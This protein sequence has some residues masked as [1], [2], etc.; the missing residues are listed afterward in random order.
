MCSRYTLI[1]SSE[2]IR[3]QFKVPAFDERLVPPR[4]NIRTDAAHHRGAPGVERA[5]PRGGANAVGADLG[6]GEGS[7]GSDLYG[8]E[9]P[10]LMACLLSVVATGRK[11]SPL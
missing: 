10:C 7:G 1:A 11:R 5:R 3:A 8:A 2:A 4:Y 9:M 6:M